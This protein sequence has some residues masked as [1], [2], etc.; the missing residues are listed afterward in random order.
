MTLDQSIALFAA[1]ATFGSLI[2]VGLQLRD[3]T[4]QRASDSL[5]KILDIN[6]ELITL[7]FS[8]PQLF[9]ILADAKNT[10]PAWT[11]RYLQLFLNQ[12]SLVFFYLKHSVSPKEVIVN[13][14]LDV[15]DSMTKSNMRKHWQEFGRL[16]PASFQAYV[17][18]IL[19]KKDESPSGKPTHHDRLALSHHEAKT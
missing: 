19:K 7:G 10:H 5:V 14:E 3:A 15:A 2:F 12:F 8:H 4:R 18:A 11:Q 6:R 9:E 1:C 17:N 13:W 16:Y